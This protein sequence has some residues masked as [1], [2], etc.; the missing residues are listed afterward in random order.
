MESPACC[1]FV[2]GIAHQAIRKN[3][4]SLPAEKRKLIPATRST[5]LRS[6]GEESTADEHQWTQIENQMT[7]LVTSHGG[8]VWAERR[9][10]RGAAFYIALPLAKEGA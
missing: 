4:I 5:A 3:E 9:A 6:P 7:D 2:W 1:A 8:R 10:E